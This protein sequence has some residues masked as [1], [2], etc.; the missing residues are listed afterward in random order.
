VSQYSSPKSSAAYHDDT[1]FARVR[2]VGGKSESLVLILK[3]AKS[4]LTKPSTPDI[5]RIQKRD[6]FDYVT[7]FHPACIELE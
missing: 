1:E 6:A 4:W 5:N 2:Y 3:W 7:L